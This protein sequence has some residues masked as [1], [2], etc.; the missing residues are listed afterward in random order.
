MTNLKWHRG[1]NISEW[2]TTT[3]SQWNSTHRENQCY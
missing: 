1:E 2:W 3:H